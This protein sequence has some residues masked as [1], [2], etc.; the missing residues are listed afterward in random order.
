VH[1]IRDQAVRQGY[2]H[3]VLPDRPQAGDDKVEKFGEWL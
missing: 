2:E 1:A 3:L